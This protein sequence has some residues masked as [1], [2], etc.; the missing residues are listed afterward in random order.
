[1]DLWAWIEDKREALESDGQDR[2]ADLLYSFP[3]VALSLEYAKFDAMVPEA[4]A[5]ARAHGD[6]WLEVYFRHWD[7]QSRVF[8]RLHGESAL[9]DAVSLVDFSH[10]PETSKCP[11]SVCTVQD[12]AACYGVVDGPGYAPERIE[13]TR[14]TLARINPEWGCFNC[15]SS[16][17]AGALHDAHGAQAALDFIEKEANQHFERGSD[18]HDDFCQRTRIEMLSELG[19]NEEALA[20]LDKPLDRN[21]DPSKALMRKAQRAL[22]LARLKRFDEALEGLPEWNRWKSACEMYSMWSNTA[23]LLV[24]AG[25]MPND[26]ELGG[27]LRAM[28]E[29]LDANGSVRTLFEVAVRSFE[30]AV[31]RKS[32]WSARDALRMMERALPRLRRPLG[33]PEKFADCGKALAQ[34]KLPELKHESPEALLAA[35]HEGEL[36]A[37]ADLPLLEAAVAKWPEDA[38]LTLNFV[39]AL[40]AVDAEGEALRVIDARLRAGKADAE[41]LHGAGKMLLQSAPERFDAWEASVLEHTTD[42]QLRVV[43]TY[44]RGARALELERRDEAIASFEKVLTVDA[45]D[46]RALKWLARS[47]LKPGVDVAAAKRALSIFEKLEGLD[48]LAEADGWDVCTAATIA[49]DWARVREVAK[50]L[51]MEPDEGEG[52]IDE[53][54]ARCRISIATKDGV[55]DFPALRTGPVTARIRSANYESPDRSRFDDEWV[56][57][58]QPLNE[59]PGEDASEEEQ[60]EHRWLYRGVFQRTKG[61]RRPRVLVGGTPDDVEA[62]EARLHEAE[63][64]W[65]DLSEEEG[66]LEWLAAVPAAIDDEKLA[67]LI[68][69]LNVQPVSDE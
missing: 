36:D 18:E 38:A 63:I 56:F 4:L 11:Q 5:L 22:I 19:R 34:L 55:D 14:E 42:P 49:G 31:E 62:L 59:G 53:A 24:R 60:G 15:I 61:T 12:L 35:L 9:R 54:W 57:D 68:A 30:L 50:S 32:A 17:H 46:E 16:E 52:P 33:A 26:G 66:V 43:P 2:L 45:D 58:A 40:E 65:T 7:L 3:N 44:W 47:L 41:L 29:R 20:L 25:T 8:G 6:P 69:P 27:I 10:G 51:G 13:V 37:E 48:A 21:D 67:A 1:M 64:V 28:C 39:R 23:V